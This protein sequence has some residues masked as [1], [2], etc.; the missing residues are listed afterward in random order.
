MNEALRIPVD[1]AL[2]RVDSVS[3][4]LDAPEEDSGRPALLLAHGAGAA[5][6]SEF[7]S[8]I[9]PGLARCGLPTLR[10]NYGYSERMTREGKRR[11]PDPR[12]R[13]EHV[14]AAALELLRARFPARP[15][16]LAGKSMGGRI[17]SYL[18]AAGE[19]AGLVFFGYPLHPA[20]KPEKLRSEHFGAIAQ[21]ALFLAGT[22]DALCT[23]ELL[24]SALETFGGVT[25][26][27]LTEQANH[28]FAVP[29]RT[30]RTRAEVLQELCSTTAEWVTSTFP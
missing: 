28:D 19:G 24:Q 2:A 13:L 22:R 21:P 18:A 14:H 23:L 6:D 16:V 3:A 26:L 8:T 17:A 5:L 11:P 4:V 12:A 25:Q 7:M 20:G 27:T 15:I 9:G 29:K 1:E 30:G 10:F